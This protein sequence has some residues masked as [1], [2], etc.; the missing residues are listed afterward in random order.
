M[1]RITATGL[2]ATP[3]SR[4]END[5]GSVDLDQFLQ[6]LITELRN[7]D[8]M[9][10]MDNN[11]LVEQLGHIREIGDHHELLARGG[12]YSQLYQRQVE[13]AASEAGA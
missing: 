3:S 9:D 13:L 10:P 11:E 7:Q 5:L 1:S 4:R 6:L 12:L 8:P 2:E